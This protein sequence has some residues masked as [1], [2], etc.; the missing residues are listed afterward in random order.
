[1]QAWYCDPEQLR[2]ARDRHG[3]FTAAGR[4]TGVD[5]TT[6]SKWWVRL[7]LEKLPKG[8]AAGATPPPHTDEQWLLDALKKAG[9]TATVSELADAADVSPRR[10]RE[11]L[12]RLED[13]GY[14]VRAKEDAVKIE[15]RPTETGE[16]HVARPELFDGD[17]FRFAVVSDTH[18]GSKAERVDALVTAYE[19]IAREGV[20][21]VYHPGDLVD[22]QDIYRTQNTETD[23]HTYEDQVAHAVDAY[24]VQAGVHTYIIAGNHDLEGAY[25]KAGADPVQ[26]FCNRRTDFTY[27]GRYSAYV[28]L[29]NGASVQM[30]HPMGGGSYATSYKSQKIVESFEGGAKPS[31]LLIGHYHKLGWF[32]SRGVQTL[33]AGTF[34]GPTTYSVRKAFGSP[35]WGF[36]IVDCRL[37]DDGSVVRFRPEL[38][39]FYFG[40]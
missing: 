20:Q 15:R 17:H 21:T 7:G 26:A 29:P 38:Y 25:G 4:A 9:D 39:P 22:G 33:L 34:Q 12:A 18:L 19:V 23:Q 6:L 30:L 28:D 37:A 2:A 24:P 16:R 8:P 5:P 32:P 10:V 3:T 35:G 27:L 14:R 36:Y 31:V 40:R 1:M 11:G 13:D